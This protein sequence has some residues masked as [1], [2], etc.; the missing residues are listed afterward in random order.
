MSHDEELA[1]AEGAAKGEDSAP[2]A[3]REEK[4][5]VVGDGSLADEVV[6]EPGGEGLWRCM[7]CGTCSAGC[8]VRAVESEFDP[9]VIVRLV[10]LGA[11]ELFE[12]DLLWLCSGCNT[13]D[14]RCPQGVHLPSL[15]KAIRN[16]GVRRG[17]VPPVM[18]VQLELLREH[19]RLLEVE[20]H[21]SRRAKMGLPELHNAGKDYAVLLELAG[22]APPAPADEADQPDREGEKKQ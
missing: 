13:C 17:K 21:N 4:E 5:L 3:G 16:V 9:R 18:A 2:A 19:G 10:A 22:C 15:I 14:E 8:P 11:T 20:E 12:G 1:V 6:A 7:S